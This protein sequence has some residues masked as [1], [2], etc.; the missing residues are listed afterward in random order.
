MTQ[1]QI[2]RV[3][4]EKNR[5]GEWVTLGDEQYKIPPLAFRDLRN[6]AEEVQGLKSMGAVPTEAQMETVEKIIHAAFHR[7]Y[8]SMKLEDVRDMLDVGNY[9]LVLTAALSVSG[10]KAA[11]DIAPGETAALIGTKSTSA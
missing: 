11:G 10:F 2:K 7:N 9:E 5:G 3:E 6:L 8:P 4:P 1:D